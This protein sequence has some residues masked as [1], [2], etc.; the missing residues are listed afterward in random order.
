MRVKALTAF[1]FSK[2]PLGVE[3][4]VVFFA[5]IFKEIILGKY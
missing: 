1:C 4:S 3:E 5:A 2:S